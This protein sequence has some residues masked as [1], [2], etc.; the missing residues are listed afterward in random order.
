MCCIRQEAVLVG[1][2]YRPYNGTKIDGRLQAQRILIKDIEHEM[3]ETDFSPDLID[4]SGVE[5]IFPRSNRCLI[6]PVA[7]TNV[8]RSL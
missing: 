2:S 4:L 6:V 5:R 7:N 8:N 3:P 1:I